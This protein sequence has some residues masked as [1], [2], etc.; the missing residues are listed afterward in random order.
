[1]LGDTPTGLQV[2]VDG[3]WFAAL[4]CQEA[5]LSVGLRGQ[6]PV[7]PRSWFLAPYPEARSR[8]SRNQY[9]VEDDGDTRVASL[10]QKAGKSQRHRNTHYCSNRT[11]DYRAGDLES[12]LQHEDSTDDPERIAKHGR[13]KC[14][15]KRAE[16]RLAPH[17]EIHHEDRKAGA[18][19]PGHCQCDG[20]EEATGD[21]VATRGNRALRHAFTIRGQY[22]RH[23]LSHNETCCRL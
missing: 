15:P 11:K 7:S 12:A 5:V 8:E 6:L 16:L 1:M 23:K 13:P 18:D 19:K 14:E 10:I 20:S 4:C 17:G 21:S 2:E 9:E 3:T 22:R